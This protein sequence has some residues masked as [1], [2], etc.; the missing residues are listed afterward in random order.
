[1]SKKLLDL[2]GLRYFYGKILARMGN[3][4]NPN[5]LINGDFQ[6]WQRGTNF[7]YSLINTGGGY[8]A[9]RWFTMF[10]KQV[11][12]KLPNG[13]MKIKRNVS[14]GYDPLTQILEGDYQNFKGK[15]M[16][17]SVNYKNIIGVQPYIHVQC[18]TNGEF[19]TLG[20][21]YSIPSGISALT[22]TIPDIIDKDSLR[23][24]FVP[25]TDAHE[26]DLYWAKLELGE[27]ATPLSPRLYGEELALCQR[28]CVPLLQYSKYRP[29]R[30]TATE[31][32]FTIPLPV[33]LRTAPTIVNSSG[34][35]VR[36]MSHQLIEGLTWSVFYVTENA[37]SVLI[38][39][40]K[41]PIGLT[42]GYCEIEPSVLFENEIY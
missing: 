8:V 9:D 40:V 12:S 35:K 36:N 21:L 17:F 10:Q 31:I 32:D 34:I 3:L 6:I 23:V 13:G 29:D 22:F 15:K 27:I 38:R 16:T 19:V 25:S 30:I 20:V 11:I 28:Y 1:M 14:S 7:D 42:D 2:D 18:K 33:P 24:S 5:L 26:H 4:S 41:N 39:G 37:A